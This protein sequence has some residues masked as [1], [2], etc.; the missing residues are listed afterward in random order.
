MRSILVLIVLLCSCNADAATRY[1][2]STAGAC[3]GNYSIANRNCTGSD[4]N[5]YAT[6]QAA[7]NAMSAG[8]TIYMRG[9][10]YTFGGGSGHGCVNIPS[11]KNGSAW[12]AGSYNTLSSYPGEW[13]IIDG[14]NNCG[15]R[16]VGVG[17]Y[18]AD[19][20]NAS[21]IAYWV[22]EK[23]EIKNARTSSGGYSWGLF[24]MGGPVKVRYMYIHDNLTTGA[25]NA[26]GFGAY[27]LHDSTVEYNYFYNNGRSS[28]S[29]NAAHI[30]MFSDYQWT[31]NLANGYSGGSSS[32]VSLKGN[33]FRYNFLDTAPTAIK[34]KGYQV[35]SGRNTAN[36]YPASDT[37]ETYGDNIH[38]NIITNVYWTG[39]LVHQDFTQV[40]KNIIDS[41]SGNIGIST[42]YEDD[43]PNTYKVTIYNNTI[44]DFNTAHN[45]L[46]YYASIF[47][48]GVGTNNGVPEAD[49][50]SFEYQYNNIID[51]SAGYYAQI[52]SRVSSVT[53]GEFISSNNYFYRP[54]ASNTNYIRY[55]GTVYNQSGWEGQ[56][57]S[58]SPKVLY[59]NAYDAGNLLWTDTSGA[60]KYIP[61]NTHIIEGSTTIANGGV[62]GAHPYLS[63]VTLPSY[64]GAVNPGDSAWVA[65]VLGLA[66]TTVLQAG[67]SGDP[68]WIEGSGTQS[69]KLNN[70]TGV[71]VT[72]H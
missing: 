69:R 15:D 20:S 38:H 56:S 50:K 44:I 8:D 22:F 62:G 31:S 3:T 17:I 59:A 41:S 35:L 64:V 55:L 14:E 32:Y 40:Y 66:S 29:D 24:V 71:R 33:I 65:G 34:Y 60:N 47:S 4:G 43:Y 57:A 63:G 67:G 28:Y 49:A 7:L 48:F 10:T 13:A 72:L 26:A 58:D 70:V 37:Y 19:Y 25:D 61:R 54:A 18:D 36:G 11:T 46:T 16:G 53:N 23:F 6:I 2:D 1:V 30:V 27:H 21:D 45:G 9:G 5:S 12:T 39:I 68:S 42:N 51:N 52:G